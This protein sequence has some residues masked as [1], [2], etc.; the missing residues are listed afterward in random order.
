ELLRWLTPG[1]A[2][3]RVVVAPATEAPRDPEVS[4]DYVGSVSNAA[5]VIAGLHR[6]EKR[7]V[8]VDSRVRAEELTHELR[9][10]GVNTFVTHASLGR[11]ERRRAEH[12]FAEGDNC[13]IVATSALEL[14]IDVGDL[15]RV[16][17]IDAPVSVA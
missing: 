3:P 8:F 1:S 2:T 9:V 6:G 10:R 11:D 4:I 13:V 17:Q 5:T 7:L 14:G 12:A 15:D 16:I